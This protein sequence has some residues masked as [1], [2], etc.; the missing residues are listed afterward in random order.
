M[1]YIAVLLAGLVIGTYIGALV[2]IENLNKRVEQIEA[3]LY[4]E[5]TTEE[6]L[7]RIFEEYED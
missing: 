3:D 1:M 2:N 6:D 7:E 4:S 5:D